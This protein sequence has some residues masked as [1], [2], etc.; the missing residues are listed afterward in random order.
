MENTDNKLENLINNLRQQKLELDNAELF[1]DKIMNGIDR[2]TQRPKSFTLGWI[3][4]VSSSAA[5]FLLGLFIYQHTNVSEITA[6]F[7]PTHLVKHSFSINPEC[8]QNVGYDHTNLLK[9][10]VCHMVANSI[11]NKR[12]Q[13]YYQLQNN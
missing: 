9:T 3:R 8:I 7:T 12:F 1:T 4:I 10:Y 6:D 11:E 13:S 5:V 2:K